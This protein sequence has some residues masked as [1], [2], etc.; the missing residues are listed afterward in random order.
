[1]QQ[2][3]PPP[4]HML[5]MIMQKK[6]LPPTHMLTMTMLLERPAQQT[7]TLAMTT[8]PMLMQVKCQ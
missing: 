4:T 8:V 5:V 1:M 3:H 2:K 7:R 6:H